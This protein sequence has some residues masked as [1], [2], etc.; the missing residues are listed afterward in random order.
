ML[1]TFQLPNGHLVVDR[2]LRAGSYA[3]AVETG[4]ALVRETWGD[5]EEL[6]V[7][8]LDHWTELCLTLR[9]LEPSVPSMGWAA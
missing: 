4:R 6:V 9:A 7:Y 1:G 8:R 2:T 3:E 5:P